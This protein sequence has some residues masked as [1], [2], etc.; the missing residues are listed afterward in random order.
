MRK[1]TDCSRDTESHSTS[2]RH[3]IQQKKLLI[4]RRKSGFSPWDQQIQATNHFLPFPFCIPQPHNTRGDSTSW[5]GSEDEPPEA[6]T[7]CAQLY[8]PAHAYGR[9]WV[10][11]LYPHNTN[12]VIW[13][14]TH[15]AHCHISRCACAPAVWPKCTFITGTGLDT[16]WEEEWHRVWCSNDSWQ[17]PIAAR[18]CVNLVHPSLNDFN[19]SSSGWNFA[20]FYGCHF[21]SLGGKI[22]PYKSRKKSF[23]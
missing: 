4:C 11:L 19:F 7:T 2:Q 13:A 9:L 22:I 21:K 1:H 6:Q 16:C 8:D 3:Y 20:S 10:W 17:K 18:S 14:Q 23:A 5:H 12:L 15:C